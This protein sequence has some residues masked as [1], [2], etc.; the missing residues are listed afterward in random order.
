MSSS[1]GSKPQKKEPENWSLESLSQ[2]DPALP[3]PRGT[4]NKPKPV[5]YAEELHL[6][7]T[8]KNGG[9]IKERWHWQGG[10]ATFSDYVVDD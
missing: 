10:T 8:L 3:H 4:S 5:S 1:R 7:L 2:D 9:L 6:K